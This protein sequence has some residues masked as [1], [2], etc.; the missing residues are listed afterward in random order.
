MGSGQNIGRNVFH[1]NTHRLTE[2]DFWL[3][4]FNSKWRPWRPFTQQSATVESRDW[5][6]NVCR[7]NMQQARLFVI[8]STVDLLSHI[9]FCCCCCSSCCLDGLFVSNRIGMKIWQECLIRHLLSVSDFW[10]GAIISRW[11]PWR[12]FTQIVLPS[13]QQLR[14]S[15]CQ[16]LIYGT[17]YIG[18][19]WMSAC[20]LTLDAAEKNSLH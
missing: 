3:D 19:C 5:K 8:R 18:T 7:E 2:L 9:S 4:V 16:F 10:Y 17:S 13:Y 1:I 6:W 12:H 14:S 20:L 15:I 11:Q